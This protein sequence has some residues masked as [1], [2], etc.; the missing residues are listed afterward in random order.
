[1]HIAGHC[2]FPDPCRG[3]VS[4]VTITER[5]AE[6]VAPRPAVNAHALCGHALSPGWVLPGD[7][8]T[9][10]SAA[11]FTCV[12]PASSQTA[13]LRGQG[14]CR[15]V[16]HPHW[17]VFALYHSL[18]PHTELR[19]RS[20]HVVTIHKNRA[21]R[22]CGPSCNSDSCSE[23]ETGRGLGRF[24][25]RLLSCPSCTWAAQVPGPFLGLPW[26]HLRVGE[27][28]WIPA[29]T[30]GRRHFSEFCGFRG[31]MPSC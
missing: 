25:P 4:R 27:V 2:R 10:P 11:R 5:P 1:M 15:S 24:Q 18:R 20:V 30:L 8:E 26:E 19:A 13:N 16:S 3:H 14:R 21:T 12:S 17:A 6:P 23:G 7:E 29:E 22:F 9:A 28:W 31:S